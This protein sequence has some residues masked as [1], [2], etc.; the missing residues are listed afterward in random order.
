L[1]TELALAE[2]ANKTHH[3]AQA[4][5]EFQALQKSAA[6]KGFGLI[7]RKASQ[8]SSSLKKPAGAM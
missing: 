6:S 7:A 8:E 5:T 4:Q 3:G 1:A 2:L